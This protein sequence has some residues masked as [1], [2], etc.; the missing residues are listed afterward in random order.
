MEKKELKLQRKASEGL[1]T[2]TISFVT[3]IATI[4]F[5][6]TNVLDVHALRD[7]IATEFVIGT[8]CKSQIC[9]ILNF[10]SNET[11]NLV[12]IDNTGDTGDTYGITASV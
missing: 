11:F 9:K 12:M 7:R 6:V 5:P 1:L 2:V 10:G 3:S 4:P 8:S